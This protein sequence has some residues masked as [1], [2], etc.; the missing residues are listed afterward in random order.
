VQCENKIGWV[1]IAPPNGDEKFAAGKSHILS[2]E[3]LGDKIVLN[4]NTLR[5]WDFGYNGYGDDYFLL[6]ANKKEFDLAYDETSPQTITFMT[7]GPAPIL[8][9]SNDADSDTPGVDWIT[10]SPLSAGVMDANGLTHYTLTFQTTEN[11]Y[12][13]P[14]TGYIRASVGED[15]SLAIPVM[16]NPYTDVIDGMSN[17]YVL[18]QGEKIS[19]KVSRAYV[20]NGT[21]FTNALRVG[22]EYTGTFG[23]GIVW[24]DFDLIDLAATKVEG[25]GN[26]AMVTVKVKDNASSRGNA[27]VAIYKN[28]DPTDIVWSYHIWIPRYAE[29]PTTTTYTT[30]TGGAVFMDRNLGATFAG[31]G[32][33]RGTGLFYQW[34]R[35]DPFPD[36]G[37]AGDEQEGGG[38]FTSTPIE[39]S[40]IGTIPYTIAH[41]GEF[42]YGQTN[43]DWLWYNDED[44]WGHGGKKTIYDPCPSGWRVP[45]IIENGGG[46]LSPW[47]QLDWRMGY[48]TS[49]A[50]Y[51][52]Y[53]GLT[54]P[55]CGFRW[56][57]DVTVKVIEGGEIGYYW[58]AMTYAS[59]YGYGLC[60][61]AAEEGDGLNIG[62]KFNGFSVRC[63]QETP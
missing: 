52:F 10:I 14:R 56:G 60:V 32:Y 46:L 8:T 13:N 22:G 40:S 61:E 11:T 5:D 42:I 58:D 44:I 38:K 45:D 12:V 18:A 25:N 43:G 62:L 35:K 4:S 49:G 55:A 1:D 27:V 59:G 24:Q 63:V 29:N 48:W 51:T 50:G 31:T 39:S 37:N 47:N 20:H 41:P 28:N 17:C 34:G 26:Q 23:I 3:F 54:I 6:A 2:L 36:T 9:L 7:D 33:D 19:F 53:S 30:E 57:V 15:L 21:N 16:Q